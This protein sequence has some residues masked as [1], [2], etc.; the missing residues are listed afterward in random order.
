MITSK[1]I[2]KEYLLKDK[3]ALGIK[4][5]KIIN[6]I[7]D[8]VWLY[9]IYLRKHEY[10]KNIKGFKILEIY[11]AIRHQMLGYKLGF[12]IPCNVFGPGLRINHY[13]L[14]VVSAKAKIGAW[15]D[16]HQGVNIGEGIDHKA[17]I[18]GENVWIGPGSK[19]YGNIK[20]GNNI[21]IGANSVV[22]KSFEEDNIRIA[23]I[24]AKII[25]K[26]KNPYTKGN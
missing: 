21:M 3:I 12:S 16:I 6:P 5:K 20:I 13:G 25:S 1:K 7:K 11:Y 4:D 8:K 9:Q 14:I 23:G 18:L 19:L 15:C 24:P 22:N 2:L 26:D 10:Y 17:P